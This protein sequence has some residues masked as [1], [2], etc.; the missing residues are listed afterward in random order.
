M[1]QPPSGATPPRDDHDQTASQPW[2]PQPYAG[3]EVLDASQGADGGP[4]SSSG[5][6]RGVLIGAGVLV[7]ALLG[8]GAAFAAA[9][10]GGGGAQPDEAVPASAVAF[11]AVDLDPSSGQ[12]IDALRFLRKFPKAADQIGKDD[13]LRKALFDSLKDD[14]T[15]TGDWATDVEPWLGDRAGV[16][17]LPPVQDGDDPGVVV[18]LAVKDQGKA[19]AG[20]AKVAGGDA[21]CEVTADFAVCA[22]EAATA[23]KAVADAERSPLSESKNYASDVDAVGDTGIVHAWVDVAAA[24]AVV[25]TTGGVD[26]TLS[27]LDASGRVAVALRFDGPHLELAGKTVG[28]K[29][30]AKAGSVSMADLPASSLAAVGVSGADESVRAAYDRLRKAAE[31]ALGAGALDQQLDAIQ[32]ETGIAVPDDVVKALGDRVSVVFGGLDGQTP[33][34]AARLSGDRGTLDKIVNAAR[35]QGGLE[36]ATAPAGADTVL[37]ST[38]AYAD[39]VAKGK[40]LGSAK[41]FTNAVPSAKDAQAVLYVDIAQVVAQLGDEMNISDED[42]KVLAPL[43][44]FGASLH[45]DGGD[46]TFDIRLTTK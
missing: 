45:R 25:P 21:S 20:L 37:A 43:S 27:G 23:K 19:K 4:E 31:Q 11:V 10:L 1:T 39:E 26:S 16:A 30:P 17:V 24:Q 36:L 34:V 44:S 35:E 46:A 8:A 6:R 38:Q 40:G 32:Q 42:R 9:K 41:A 13:D 18:V 28:A 33:K 5:R 29:L 22:E 15:V 2:A 3:G 14:G 12:K 7:V